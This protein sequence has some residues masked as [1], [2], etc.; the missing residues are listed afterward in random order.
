MKNRVFKIIQKILAAILGVVALLLVFSIFPVAG[1]KMLIVQSGSMQPAIKQGSLIVVSSADD[2]KINKVITFYRGEI[3]VTHRIYD[4]R[5]QAGLPIYTVKGDA[6]SLPDADEVYPNQIMGKVI[7][8]LPYLGYAVDV[9]KKPVGFM[10]I[11]IIPA[12]A[13]IYDELKKIKK[14][15]NH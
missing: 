13:I 7:L 2:Y 5:L 12:M 1:Y 14:S 11:I 8:D 3:A 10:L 6:N 15:I 4:M 9:A